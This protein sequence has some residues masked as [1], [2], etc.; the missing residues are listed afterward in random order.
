[1]F[2]SSDVL[3]TVMSAVSLMPADVDAPTVIIVNGEENPD[4]PEVGH[5]LMQGS[6]AQEDEG[7]WRPE[8][9]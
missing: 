8:A 2:C 1:M 4:Y 7:K 3:V 5:Q 6:V 9:F